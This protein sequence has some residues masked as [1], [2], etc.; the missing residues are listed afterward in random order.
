MAA[1]P[2]GLFE[3]SGQVF[4]E[5]AVAAQTVRVHR[6]THETFATP[7]HP[8]RPVWRSAWSPACLTVQARPFYLNADLPEGPLL[9]AAL[10]ARL[11]QKIVFVHRG[12]ADQPR[13]FYQIALA[14]QEAGAAA[15]VIVDVDGR[16]SAYDQQCLPGA[17][18]SR[19]EGFAALDVPSLW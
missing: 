8:A 6:M 7:A 15:V 3:Y 17:E 9:P 19:G 11:R 16:C 12:Q 2:D 5:L 13:P 4:L 18:K 14:A 10:R 1:V